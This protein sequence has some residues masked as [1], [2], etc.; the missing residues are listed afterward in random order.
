[1]K[2]IK[3][4]WNFLFVGHW[5][6]GNIGN[7]RKDVGNLIRTFFTAFRGNKST[8]LIL[9]TAGASPCMMDR[10]DLLRKIRE[11]KMSCGI[12]P[13][14]LPS[15][16]L[17]HADLFDEEMNDLYNHPKVKAHVSFTHGEG[18]GR[19][20]LEASLSGKPVIA[21]GWSGHVDFLNKNNS[22]LIAGGLKNVE[23]E[24]FPKNIYVEGQ[25]WFQVDYRDAATKMTHIRKN[26][27]VYKNRG[28]KQMIFNKGKFS[29]DS[30]VTRLGNLLD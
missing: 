3:E 25:Q 19:P 27:K 2:E 18:F 11:I 23:K 20:L 21:P 24:S 22:V 12:H 28:M 30:M 9:K 13:S 29:F 6:Q 14:Q 8:G 1:M 16:Y 10:E 15:V 7:D 26:L 5:L 17:L 4:N